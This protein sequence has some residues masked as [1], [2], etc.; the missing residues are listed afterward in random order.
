MGT[1]D[2]PLPSTTSLPST[3]P[4]PPPAQPPSATP[5]PP[6]APGVR[7]D[8]H[9]GPVVPRMA[10][11]L[12]L[13][14]LREARGISQEEAGAVI[15]ASH[16]KI[17]R[18]ELGRTG[19][20]ARDITDLLTLYGV[21]EDATRATVLDL[22]A[23]AN[24][25]G[26]W[27]AYSD[28]LPDPAQA[29]LGIEQSA[30]LIRCW[31][32]Q[33]VPAL[34]QTPDYARAVARATHRDADEHELARRVEFQHRRSR[35]LE[36]PGATRLW[37]VIDEAALRRPVG[38]AETM[39]GQL[40]RLAEAAALPGV[41]VQILPFAVGCHAGIGGPVTLVRLPGGL[42]PD[43]AFLEQPL[44]GGQLDRRADVEHYWDVVNHLAVEAAPPEETD[45]IVRAVLA[46]T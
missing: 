15:R 30:A 8:A 10:L 35:V 45:A 12:R 4:L 19:C 32:S 23:Q 20:K 36:G 3:T 14:R 41:T 44:M 43:V 26:W 11:G 9:A 21:R 16:S 25:P 46:G 37:A 27:H 5:L 6:A 18:L 7:P 39:R 42:L 2:A 31:T 1:S 24:R 29:Y 13:R 28:L 17:C 38:G 40:R 34:L 33:T 22:A